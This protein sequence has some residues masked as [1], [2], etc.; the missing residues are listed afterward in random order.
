MEKESQSIFDEPKKISLKLLEEI[1]N[2]FAEDAKLSSGTFGEVYK[3]AFKD[4]TEIAVNKLRLMPGI[5]ERRFESEIG[6]LMKLKHENITQIVGFCDEEE[7]VLSTYKGKPVAALKIHRAVCLEFVPRG[8]LCKLLSE[9]YFGLNWHVRFKIIKGICEGLNYLHDISIEH[10]DLNL[11]NIFVDN[12]MV[13]KISEFGLRRLVSEESHLG[14]LESSPAESMDTKI[15]SKKYDIFSLGVIIKK[16]VISG[17]LDYM[18]IP[19]MEDKAFIEHV[20]DSWRKSLQEISSYTSLEAYCKQVQTCIEIAVVCMETDRYKRPTMKDI[21]C[22]LNKVE[23]SEDDLWSQIEQEFCVKINIME[24]ESHSISNEPKKIPFK[25]LEEVT[26]GFSDEAKLGSGSFGEVYKGVLKDGTKIAVKKLRFMPGIDEMQFANELGHL[27]KLNHQNIVKIVGFCDETKEVVVPYNGMLVVASEIHRALCLEFVPNGSLGKL[28]SEKFSG[29]N[30]HARFKII[31]GICEGL[32]Y[33]H[34]VSIMHFDLK[35]D[36]ILLDDNMVPKI[37]DFGISRIVGEENTLSTMSSLGTLGFMPPEFITKQIISKEFDIFS[38]GVIIKRIVVCGLNDYMSIADMED[39]AFIEHVHDSWKKL[40]ETSSYAS[41]DVDCKQV[42]TCIQIAVVCMET[43]RYKR[44]K[45]KD[46]ICEL[47]EVE[48]REDG[49]RSQ[50]EQI[51]K[52]QSILPKEDI[53]KRRFPD[54]RPD[55]GHLQSTLPMEVSSSFLRAITDGFSSDRKI[56][57]GAFGTFYKG[58][59]SDGTIIAVK[60][61]WESSPVEPYK[62]FQ[63]EAGNIIGIKHDNIVKLLSFCHEEQKKVVLNNG[64][65]IVADIVE[66]FLCYEYVPNGSLDDHIFGQSRVDWATCFRIIKGICQGI[67]FLHNEMDRRVLHMNLKPS[68][69]LLDA[70]MVPKITE[71][72]ISKVFGKEQTVMVT[73]NIVGAVGYMAPEYL[74]RG[75]I[76]MQSDIYSLGLIILEIATGEKNQPDNDDACGMNFIA[77]IRKVWTDEYILWKYDLDAASFQEV[78]IC[79]ETG[80][81]C[82]EL[83]RRNRPLVADIL[84]KLNGREKNPENKLDDCQKKKGK[85]LDD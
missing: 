39:Q 69:I 48:T 52:E 9:N 31:K 66:C 78:K 61:I 15:I 53:P 51:H 30:W 84:D 79:I 25:L 23:T 56:G 46:I 34:D 20:Q 42:R 75:E 18:T 80:L 12:K 6:H 10:F 58:F 2:G 59:L 68:T 26:N 83:Q 7:E 49:S 73:G 64:R 19:D 8:T 55:A 76:S 43:D 1:T 35:P 21:I 28:I 81:R 41:L 45:M 14:N 44:P 4:G 72:C 27:K 17:V 54:I 33:L 16:I 40:Q 63:N 38:L 74:Y 36:N 50:I 67:H 77:H 85:K 32:K 11:N 60:K 24:K 62:Q 57:R 22:R 29:L 47:N 37:A 71:F 13:P 5:E 3:A 65:Y 70:D 82:V